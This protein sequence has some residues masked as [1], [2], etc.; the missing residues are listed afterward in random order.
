[1]EASMRTVS[2]PCYRS[3]FSQTFSLSEGQECV[4][5]D[6]LPDVASI[7]CSSA[8]PL[9]RSKDLSEGRVRLEANVPAR[10]TCLGE[11]GTMFCMDVNIPF[12]LSAQ[13][14]GLSEGCVCIVGLTLRQLEA[15]M[16]NPRKLS[17][18]A[19]LQVQVDCFLSGGFEMAAAPEACEAELHTLE[20]SATVSTVTAVT[21]KTFVLTDEYT[22]PDQQSAAAEILSQSAS[23]RTQEIKTVGS[24]VIASGVLESELLY[25]SEEGDVCTA[26]FQTT[27]SQIIEAD[28]ETDDASVE[29]RILLSGMYYEIIPGTEMRELA[30][31]VHLVAQA[32]VWQKQSISYLADVYSNAYPLQV[33]REPRSFPQIARDCI[34]RENGRASIDTPDTVSR[35]IS[36]RAR[37]LSADVDGN[38]ITGRF[39]V[40][41]CYR[42]G[43]KLCSVERICSH[44]FTLDELGGAAQVI[45]FCISELSAV[46]ADNGAELRFSAEIRLRILTQTEL[47]CITGVEWDESAGIDTDELPTLVLL[48]ADSRE[49]LW[50]L[51]KDNCSTVE[52][53]CAANGLEEAE[54]SWEKLLIIPKAL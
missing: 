6:T 37:P 9:I 49:D 12:Y 41:L 13:E 36:C 48:R 53:I 20:R 34:L 45:G 16:L 24:K 3:A 26:A 31:E 18:R 52:A 30:M 4:V 2:Y 10:I 50:R 15:R 5:S 51:A 11:D 28:C 33:H 46:P 38:S 23:I 1:M 8:T 27:F 47:D 39:R 22:L 7:F 32:V 19:D 25:R 43:E 14:E 40:A 54:E 35:V 17:V 21:E 42:S 44:S 29:L